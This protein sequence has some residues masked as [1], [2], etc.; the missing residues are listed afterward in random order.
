MRLVFRRR[1]S[2]GGRIL[3][4]ESGSR[5]ITERLLPALVRNH[6][7]AAGIDLVTCF[8]GEP[9]SLPSSSV[10]FRVADYAGAPGRRRLYRELRARNYSL[11]GIICSAEP[12]MTKWK[13]AIAARVPAKVFIINENADYFWFDYSHWR[14]LSY[15][16][17]LRSGLAGTGAA[18]TL[19]RIVTFPVTLLFLL[20]YALVVHT[21]RRL[22]LMF[23]H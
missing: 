8:P 21:R 14:I 18:R 5:H 6:P 23:T 22:R 16:A 7:K 2:E 12:I 19:A 11:A 1:I 13:W 20:L 9:A 3:V 10:V 17:L 4:V 15:F